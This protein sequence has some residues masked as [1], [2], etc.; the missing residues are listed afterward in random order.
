MKHRFKQLR[1]DASR[2]R[3][4]SEEKLPPPNVIDDWLKKQRR[5]TPSQQPGLDLPSHVPKN[6]PPKK[7][8]KRGVV[9]IPIEPDEGAN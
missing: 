3:S 7:D 1:T 6:P 8:K 4:A 9:I 5:K 2:R